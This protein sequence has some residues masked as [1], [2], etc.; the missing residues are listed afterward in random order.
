LVRVILAWTAIYL[1]EVVPL[2]L[3]PWLAA[4]KNRNI[5]VWL[6]GVLGFGIGALLVLFFLKPARPV[7]RRD[8]LS[9]E[10]EQRGYAIP[11]ARPPSFKIEGALLLVG[12]IIVTA[13]AF[14][15]QHQ[16]DRSRLWDPR[17]KYLSG[18]SIRAN[19]L[20]AVTNMRRADGM[21]YGSFVKARM[22]RLCA[23]LAT[24]KISFNVAVSTTTEERILWIVLPNYPGN[25]DVCPVLPDL[26]DRPIAGLASDQG[27]VV[28]MLGQNIEQKES[29]VP[30]WFDDFKQG[31]SP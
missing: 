16:N 24:D 20:T 6:L 8:A 9:M 29:V 12:A 25:P 23:R 7:I 1:F 14:G 3:T 18:K 26:L 17:L 2:C 4:R 31:K 27:L 15:L 5:V 21:S 11:D 13:S 10:E 22:H 28:G 19:I 30:S